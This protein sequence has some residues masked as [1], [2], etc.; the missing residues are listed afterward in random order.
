MRA[1]AGVAPRM[2]ISPASPH[3]PAPLRVEN[4]DRVRWW[5]SLHRD[6]EPPDAQHRGVHPVAGGLHGFESVGWWMPPS[7]PRA[8]GCGSDGRFMTPAG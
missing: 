3:Q 4:G 5:V 8:A 7:R 6:L 2:P 1:P